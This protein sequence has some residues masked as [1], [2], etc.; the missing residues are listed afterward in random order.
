M[1]RFTDDWVVDRTL[2][3]YINGGSCA[4]CGFSHLFVPNGVAGMIHDI[5]DL[6][7]DATQAEVNAALSSSSPW[8][9]EMR[10]QVWADR[11]R[12]R[13]KMKQE[14][15]KYQEFWN[16][17]GQD[18]TE[19]CTTSLTPKQLQKLL[20]LP[21]TEITDSLQSQYGIHS[22]FAI[23]LCAVT[24]QVANFRAT[25]Y[26]VDG[27]GTHEVEFEQALVFDKRGGFTL[28]IVDKDKSTVHQETLQ[29][30][31]HRIQSLGGPKLLD[32]GV[33]KQ[34]KQDEGGGTDDLQEKSVSKPSFR[35]D[36]R[37][38]RLLVA[39]YW[40]DAFREKYL[41]CKQEEKEPAE[42]GMMETEQLKVEE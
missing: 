36:R 6:E 23:V 27:I 14:M 3:E 32:R 21:R 20:Q 22:A 25:G 39:R 34:Q 35:S 10:D 29:I 5:S 12:L 26:S 37:I 2:F 11:V 28:K 1:P 13:L 7:T 15:V 41:K 8:P 40:A 9:P 38:V 24:E 33:S 4:C 31:L 19:W 18:F 42:V 17:H 16:Q 30:L